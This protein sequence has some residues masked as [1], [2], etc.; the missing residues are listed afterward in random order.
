MDSCFIEWEASSTDSLL[1]SS[2]KNDAIS[3]STNNKAGDENESR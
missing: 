3:K 2:S 1:L